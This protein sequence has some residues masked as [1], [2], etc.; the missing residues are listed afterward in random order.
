MSRAICMLCRLRLVHLHRACHRC[1]RNMETSYVLRVNLMTSKHWSYYAACR[2]GLLQ[3]AHDVG[4]ERLDGSG[5]H[6]EGRHA[7]IVAKQRKAVL[8]ARLEPRE[9]LGRGAREPRR[10]RDVVVP[11]AICQALVVERLAV[12]R[13]GPEDGHVAPGGGRHAIA[14]RLAPEAGLRDVALLGNA[15]KRGG[16]RRAVEAA[17]AHRRKGGRHPAPRCSRRRVSRVCGIHET[18]KPATM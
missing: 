15:R 11:G 8:Q 3:P 18:T 4:A 2:T 10:R 6:A 12:A 14:V 1:G 5:V 17:G 7:R 9:R 16:T 13:D